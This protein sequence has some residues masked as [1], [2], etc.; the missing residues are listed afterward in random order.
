MK[1]LLV[2][3]DP[4]ILESLEIILSTER[5][6]TIVGTVTSGVN[7]I[8]FVR[9][10]P[11][12]MILMDIQMPDMD[13]IAATKT[14]HDEFPSLKIIMLT[15]FHDYQNIHRSLQAGA[16]G[17]M[18][19]SDDTKKQIM[20]IKTVFAG[21]PV[22]S[23]KALKTYAKPMEESTLSHRENEI[24]FHVANGLSNREIATRLFITEGTVRN[25]IS[26]ILDKVQLRDRTQLAIYYW[27]HKGK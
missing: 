16:C 23:E 7:A 2:D 1:I 13:G 15:T 20:T 8:Q 17:Y 6:L 14:I 10:H 5:D 27:Q 26:I 4:M 19:K 25:T 3:D 22:I 18:L 11:V 12:D 24:L 9:E 21:L